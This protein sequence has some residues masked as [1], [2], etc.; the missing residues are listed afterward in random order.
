MNEIN[1]M[2][3][4]Y[5]E[6]FVKARLLDVEQ[7]ERYTLHTRVGDSLADSLIDGLGND[8]RGQEWIRRGIE[9][10][11]HAIPDAPA[12]V[13]A[14]FAAIEE[15]PEWWRPE[16][17]LAGC[18]GFHRHAVMFLIAFVGAVLI[19]GFCTLISKSFSITGRIVDQGVRRL[20]QNNR[21]LIEIFMPGGLERQSDGWKLSVRIRL[22]HAQVR[23]L[24]SRSEE[25]DTEAWGTPLSA[26]HMGYA[27]ASFSGLLLKRVGMLGVQLSKEERESFMMIWRY[28]G[29][30]MGVAP[31]MLF[32]DEGD[33]LRIQR[34][35]HLC[36]P[37][38]GLESC[39]LA[40][41]LLQAAPIVAG[42]D[43]P[44]QRRQL[45]KLMYRTSRAL[46]GD[47]MAN[48]LG[49][50]PANTFGTLALI[51][52]GNKADQFLQRMLP[53]IGRWRRT[54]QFRQMLDLAHYAEKG[55][56][57]RIPEELH[58]ERDK[59]L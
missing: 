44:G 25:W 39:Q 55:L 23:S 34:I 41:S 29:H 11:P 42:F 40:N 7:A 28:S 1:G 51:S 12:E 43:K 27:T 17:A 4:E 21:Q 6:G 59:P 50:P 56:G 5:R 58:A 3:G 26:A 37:P 30:L 47:E 49:F 54:S 48:Q 52:M 10:G 38:P 32:R 9:G 33:A 8:P 18:Q 14:F 15:V 45:V 57:Y 31:E 19:E 2:P 35:G 24:L 16:E 53:A 22:V 46:I 36:E 20:K 13:R